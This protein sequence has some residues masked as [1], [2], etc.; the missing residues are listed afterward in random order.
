MA[1]AI[2]N[3]TKSTCSK[4]KYLMRSA[5]GHISLTIKESVHKKADTY[6]GGVFL[7]LTII[8]GFSIGVE[9]VFDQVLNCEC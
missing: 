3:I 1:A 2:T 4:S 6:N 7:L 5:T 9:R 8:A